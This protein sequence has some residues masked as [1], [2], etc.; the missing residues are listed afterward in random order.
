MLSENR[1]INFQRIHKI[2]KYC[3][4]GFNVILGCSSYFFQCTLISISLEWDRG[5]H[6]PAALKTNNLNTYRQEPAAGTFASELDAF[7]ISFKSQLIEFIWEQES[8]HPHLF[9]SPSRQSYLNSYDVHVD[10]R[11]F[12]HS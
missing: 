12:W 3:K 11:L 8:L 1:F 9:R 2:F 7:S 10:G 6:L 4:F 5:T